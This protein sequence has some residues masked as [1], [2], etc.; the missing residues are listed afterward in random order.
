MPVAAHECDVVVIGGGPAGSAI[1]RLLATWGHTV[2]I[3]TQDE[4]ESRG[5]AESLPPSTRKL[6]AEIGV[7]ETITEAGFLQSTGNT[8]WWGTRQ[9]SVERFS[10]LH[11]EHG[12]Q[13][14]RPELDKLLLR[15]ARAAG[16]HVMGGTRVVR[17]RLHDQRASVEYEHQGTGGTVQCRFAVDCSGRTGIIARQGFRRYEANFQMQALVG[18]WRCSGAWGFPDDTHTFVETFTDGWAWS[19]PVSRDTRQFAV[20]V[21]GATTDVNRGP[22]LK[23]TYRRE[24]AKAIRLEALSRRGQ[25]DQVWACDA[26]LY[27]AAQYAGPS[28]LLVGDAA[29][30]ID[31]LSSFGVKKALA[32]AWLGAIAIHTMLLDAQRIVPALELFSEREREMFA[33]SLHRSREY[34][35][36]AYARH[37]HPFWARRAEIDVAWRD[38]VDEEALARSPDVQ[39]AF[40]ALKERGELRFALNEEARRESRPVIR[41]HEIVLDDAFV[42]LDGVAVRFLAGVDLVALAEMSTRSTDIPGLFDA[43]CRSQS[44]VPLPSLLLA[45][46]FLSAQR[47]VCQSA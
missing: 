3:L 46:S 26:S 24:L 36:E 19:V 35:R 21:D 38:E 8:V 15:S 47:I 30:R 17:V 31:P 42:G 9:G 18:T 43:Y 39:A 11:G 44:A 1:A 12:I 14:L 45:L 13:V 28:F 23:E 41:G 34:A 33:S 27:D 4:D 5:L 16:A 32:S 2:T 40:R 25:L 22:T 10:T 37:P 6:L 20:M 7:L 29:S